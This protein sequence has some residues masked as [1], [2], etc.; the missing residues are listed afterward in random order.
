MESTD[1]ESRHWTKP[2]T[3]QTNQAPPALS[4]YSPTAL[5]TPGLARTGGQPEEAGRPGPT[6]PSTSTRIPSTTILDDASQLE[7]AAP[8]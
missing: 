5:R 3:G 1:D 6:H 8:E 7:A 2:S 4:P